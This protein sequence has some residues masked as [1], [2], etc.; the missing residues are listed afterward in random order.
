V[1]DDTGI[2]EI[3]AHFDRLGVNYDSHHIAFLRN[4]RVQQQK[5]AGWSD[6]DFELLVVNGQAISTAS[7][8]PTDADPKA[9]M[10]E[11]EKKIQNYGWPHVDGRPAGTYYKFPKKP[12]EVP[13]FP[14][15]KGGLLK[16]L[17]ICCG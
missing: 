11:D 8:A 6:S 16:M 9:I 3:I 15:H 17:A 13:F 1:T 14:A 10:K 4:A 5:C 2:D 12:G 7:K